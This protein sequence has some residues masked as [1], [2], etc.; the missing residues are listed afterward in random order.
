MSCGCSSNWCNSSSTC[1]SCINKSMQNVHKILFDCSNCDME[2]DNCNIL[3]IK[4]FCNG[5]LTLW[6]MWESNTSSPCTSSQW[7]CWVWTVY[8]NWQCVPC[9]LD[10]QIGCW[11]SKDQC[12]SGYQYNWS[13]WLCEPSNPC[14]DNT[15]PLF[16]TSMP[17]VSPSWDN[18]NAISVNSWSNLN[19]ILWSATD[20][21]WDILTYS[22]VNWENLATW[23]TVSLSS[24][25]L[26][27]VSWTRTLSWVAST[28]WEYIFDYRASDWCS[29][30]ERTLF[31]TII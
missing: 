13:T 24:L 15:I 17:W 27:F 5:I 10:W 7:E 18:S 19:I 2:C 1:W 22:L 28:P 20:A 26:S 29:Y 9:G 31:I 16:P 21:D 3:T 6:C 12:A 14:A 11:S 25:W 4:K 23:L 8:H 30:T